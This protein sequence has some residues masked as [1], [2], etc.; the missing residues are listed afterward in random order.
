MA[1]AMEAL[2]NDSGREMRHLVHS[3]RIDFIAPA[4]R[5]KTALFF[6]VGHKAIQVCRLISSVGG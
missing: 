4:A 3:E 1:P 6:R 2:E 5:L